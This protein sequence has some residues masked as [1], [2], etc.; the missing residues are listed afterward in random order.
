MQRNFSLV[1]LIKIV[2]GAGFFFNYNNLEWGAFLCS[3]QMLLKRRHP[4]T[5]PRPETTLQDNIICFLFF[6]DF[7]VLEKNRSIS[8]FHMANA[9]SDDL[10]ETSEAKK[11]KTNRKMQREDFL[12]SQY[13]WKAHICASA[14][15]GCRDKIGHN[16]GEIK[17]K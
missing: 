12:K 7:C 1:I 13:K 10:M 4:T 11:R 3:E 15:T 9:Q 17:V 6:G 14:R 8:V 16:D 5:T 2:L